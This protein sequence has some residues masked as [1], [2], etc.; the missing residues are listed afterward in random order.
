M[1]YKFSFTDNEIYGAED[2]N[3]ITRRLVSGGVADPFTDGVPYNLSKFNEVGDL[4]YTR[5]VVPESV[6]ALK[7]EK[8]SDNTILIH[9]G[10]AF[11]ESGAVIEIEEGGHELSFVPGVKNYVA[12]RDD[13]SLAGTC[14]PVCNTI[15]AAGKFF[16][17]LAEITE[18]GDVI[19][20][21]I[22]ARGKLPGYASSG[23]Y[24]MEITDVIPVENNRLQSDEVRYTIGGNHYRYMMVLNN[25]GE[26]YG[27]LGVYNF[28]DG[29]ILSF[30][31]QINEFGG[32]TGSVS[33]ERLC[34]WRSNNRALYG[35]VS[36]EGEE[37][38]LSLEFS[39]TP[40]GY[41]SGD[42]PITMYLV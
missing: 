39:Y 14:Y 25:T 11:F 27:I 22:Y 2:L 9:P 20:M 29:N 13:L 6:H 3:N 36:T 8:N 10:V 7:V 21:R 15:G 16:V 35:T 24:R 12:L 19:D 38:V 28:T 23:N 5:G 4:L 31:G 40:D 1:S 26:N 42:L 32:G 30:S 33:T 37:L 18:T 34:L 41:Y 17:K